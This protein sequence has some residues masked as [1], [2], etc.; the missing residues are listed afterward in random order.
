[1]LMAGRHLFSLSIPPQNSG[2][3][4]RLPTLSP[5]G[6]WPWA[7]SQAPAGASVGPWEVVFTLDFLYLSDLGFLMTVKMKLVRR[8]ELTASC[9]RQTDYLQTQP[10]SPV[11]PNKGAILAHLDERGRQGAEQAALTRAGRHPPNQSQFLGGLC[12]PAQGPVLHC[13]PSSSDSHAPLP[14]AQLLRPLL[15]HLTRSPKKKVLEL[16]AV[17]PHEI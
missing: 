9:R 12:S 15:F 13:L 11:E 2:E 14:T 6:A 8:C 7:G 3:R 4:G 17:A 10:T 1:M 16:E 5:T